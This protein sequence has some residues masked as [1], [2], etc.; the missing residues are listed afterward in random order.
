MKFAKDDQ[1]RNTEIRKLYKNSI[2]ILRM[3]PY[4][5]MF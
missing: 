4:L 5:E 1:K 3:K 2:N